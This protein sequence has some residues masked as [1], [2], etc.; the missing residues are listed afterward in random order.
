MASSDRASWE[1]RYGKGVG[2][3]ERPPSDFLA[4]HVADLPRGRVLDLAAGDGRNAL[5]LARQRYPVDAI[6][7]SHAALLRLA[8]IAKRESLAVHVVQADLE[9]YLL[10]ARR[11]AAVVNIRYLQRSLFEPMRESVVPG[12][13]VLFET[14]LRD[15]A[16]LGHPRN[17]AFL[18]ERGELR[19]RFAD[20]ELIF[21]EEG[22]F[23]AESGDAYLARM[24]A[25][26]PKCE[27]HD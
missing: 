24:I 15:Q 13:V 4:A 16:R 14:F 8:E 7:H 6:D 26:R 23:T 11:Y 2:D 18:L 25:R 5:F 1:K 17:P 20:F 10:P 19:A 21:Y 27:E 22:C 9:Q 3:L 12:G